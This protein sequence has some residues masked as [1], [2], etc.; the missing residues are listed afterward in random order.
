MRKGRGTSMVVISGRSG[1][2]SVMPNDTRAGAAEG[3]P[4]NAKSL[5]LIGWKR[6]TRRLDSSGDL[7][8]HGKVGNGS[9]KQT[10]LPAHRYAKYARNEISFCSLVIMCILP[11]QLLSA[12]RCC[13]DRH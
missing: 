12:R 3:H 13:V 2:A 9:G 7:Q 11:E 6:K 4:R 8:Q 10:I 1:E 5:F